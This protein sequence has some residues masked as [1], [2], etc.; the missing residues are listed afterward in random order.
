MYYIKNEFEH[1]FKDN[2]PHMY[3]MA[4][5]IVE[6]AEDAK[7]AVH[8]VFTQMWRSKPQV[9]E[10]SI[11]GYL[12]AATRNQCLHHIS[13]TKNAITNVFYYNIDDQSGSVIYADSAGHFTFWP[14]L[15]ADTLWTAASGY[16]PQRFCP[17]D[18]TITIRLKHIVRLQSAKIKAKDNGQSGKKAVP[19]KTISG[20]GGPRSEGIPDD[21][22]MERRMRGIN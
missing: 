11:R 19:V 3:R 5:S 9:A 6:N 14:P 21:E 20:K 16:I 12:L 17:A 18:S 10:E 15:T 22:T 4:F 2:Y 8:Q 1:L 7:D 13:L